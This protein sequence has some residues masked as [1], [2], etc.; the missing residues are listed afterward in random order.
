MKGRIQVSLLLAF[1]AIGCAR[2]PASAGRSMSADEIKAI[3]GEVESTARASEAAWKGVSCDNLA[4]VLQ[5]WD[6]SS[7]G[8][9]HS[10]ERGTRTF[11][12]SEWADYVRGNVCSAGTGESVVDSVVV[13]VVSSDVATAI[14]NYHAVLKDADGMTT[15][16][17]GKILRVFRRTSA[18]W[19]IRASMST[20]S[21]LQK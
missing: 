6:G 13:S 15:E 11:S 5:Y 18:G 1:V 21:D 3:A 8:L 12:D 17:S 20:H 4:P 10:S 9:V 19:K 2:P 16:R 14:M 7:P